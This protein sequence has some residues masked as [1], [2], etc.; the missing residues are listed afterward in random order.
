MLSKTLTTACSLYSSRKQFHFFSLFLLLKPKS[1]ILKNLSV[2]D[3]TQRGLQHLT[4]DLTE[5]PKQN[6][7]QLIAVHI[8][9]PL[10]YAQQNCAAT[11]ISS[12][13]IQICRGK[14][15]CTG[16]LLI[17]IRN[18]AVIYRLHSPQ[19]SCTASPNETRC[20][21]R[22]LNSPE[23]CAMWK[24]TYGSLSSCPTFLN[25]LDRTLSILSPPRTQL[26]CW[27]IQ[28]LGACGIC[29]L[30]VLEKQE[31]TFC[32]KET[33]ALCLLYYFLEAL[34]LW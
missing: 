5:F 3:F 33:S 21:G 4:K 1:I 23:S 29:I 10:L 13:S 11:H 31:K 25:N 30:S 6:R 9:E 22:A 27:D 7:E 8:T 17:S 24:R 2:S 16:L 14:Y 15:L 26:D 32:T 18:A 28:L 12:H 34:S 20:F 19:A